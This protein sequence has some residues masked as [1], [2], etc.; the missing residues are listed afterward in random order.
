MNDISPFNFVSIII[1]THLILHKMYSCSVLVGL[2]LVAV[3]NG[4]PGLIT[5]PLYNTVSYNISNLWN[6]T[7]DTVSNATDKGGNHVTVTLKGKIT[8]LYI[9]P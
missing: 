6:G 7:E 1:N 5:P 3:S 4:Y 8:S 9:A 2:L